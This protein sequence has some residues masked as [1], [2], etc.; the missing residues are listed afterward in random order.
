MHRIEKISKFIISCC[1]LHNL[2]ID[3]T[4]IYIYH[5]AHEEMD[6]VDL[7]E[8]QEI[9]DE[10]LKRLGEEKRNRIK[11][12]FLFVEDGNNCN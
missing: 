2:C 7:A 6:D 8:V 11:D 4:N 9:N 5:E 3:N 12:S 10:E 1:V